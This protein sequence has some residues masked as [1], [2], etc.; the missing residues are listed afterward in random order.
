MKFFSRILSLIL[1]LVICFLSISSVVFA[2]EEDEYEEKD[3]SSCV[4]DYWDMVLFGICHGTEAFS[5]DILKFFGVDSDLSSTG[6]T[7]FV[8]M[9]AS[10]LFNDCICPF[11]DDYFHHANSIYGAEIGSDD[12]GYYAVLRCR[13]CGDMFNYYS[14]DLELKY[15]D[16]VDFLDSSI[17]D[18]HLGWYGYVGKTVSYNSALSG[19]RALRNLEFPFFYFLKQCGVAEKVM[20]I[21]CTSSYLRGFYFDEY[22]RLRHGLFVNPFG[23]VHSTY[24]T[25]YDF[26]EL[27]LYSSYAGVPEKNVFYDLI[28]AESYPNFMTTS[29][30]YIDWDANGTYS[31]EVYDEYFSIYV[32]SKGSADSIFSSSSTILKFP[33]QNSAV[34]HDFTRLNYDY[35][36]NSFVLDSGYVLTQ[37]SGTDESSRMSSVAQFIENYNVDN[38]YTANPNIVN[39]YIGSVDDD[40]KITDYYSPSLYDE[41][42]LVF[43][44]PVTGVQYLTSGWTYDYT[45]R[46][47]DIDLDAGVFVINDTDITRIL[48]IYGDDA[49]TIDYFDSGGAVVQSDSY[50][51]VM[52]ASSSCALYGHS[53]TVET[54]KEPTCI[55]TGERVYTCSVCGDQKVED[56]PMN[57]HSSTFSI[58]KEPTC[59]ESGVG[60]YTCSTCGTQYTETIDPLGHDWLSTNHMDTVY[61]LPADTACPDCGGV[62]FTCTLDQDAAV[63]TCSCAA[64]GTSWT[65]GAVV[66][67]GYT[68]YECSRCGVTKTECEIDEGDG[69]FQSIGNFIADG[70]TWCTDKLSQLVDSLSSI[71]DSFNA[72]LEDL[73]DQGGETP[74]LMGALIA[75]LPEDLMAV[76]WFFVVG[77]VLVFVYKKWMS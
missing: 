10:N 4:S 19:A 64:C 39:Y 74:A 28:S 7:A 47:Y 9:T 53:Y 60:L 73:K 29:C 16:Y 44:E 70:I 50:A 43:T 21:G 20:I 69:L 49:V 41:N 40:G 48:C 27:E 71:T 5:S 6:L 72:Y 14:A 67:S 77:V 42:T 35:H 32:F 17:S 62:E 75:L 63:Y 11:S 24:C 59:T 31:L 38:S 55:S 22:G 65:V 58:F 76:F 12:Y 3:Y 2:A 34:V 36:M 66:T 30:Y 45:T 25:M 26:N 54:T 51:Y 15:N 56:V 23:A 1:V 46:S 8:S 57:G 18:C 13:L 37:P 61:A 52:V 68:K 33:Y